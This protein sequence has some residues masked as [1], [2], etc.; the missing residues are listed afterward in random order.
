[1]MRHPVEFS[2]DV[3]LVLYNCI[4]IVY[5]GPSCT[6]KYMFLCHKCHGKTTI[7]K[8]LNKMYIHFISD[9]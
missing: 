3:T 8:I 7:C 4:V 2:M 9:L 5:I 6:Y 1:M